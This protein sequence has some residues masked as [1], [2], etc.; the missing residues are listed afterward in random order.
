MQRISEDPNRVRVRPH[1]RF[2][3]R[4]LLLAWLP[5]LVAA[6][7]TQVGRVVCM[8]GSRGSQLGP[9]GSASSQQIEGES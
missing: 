8:H 9:A 4:V 2:L 6:V 3:Q 1:P 5:S 7:I